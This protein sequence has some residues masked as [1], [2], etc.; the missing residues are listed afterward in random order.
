M[1]PYGAS[2][3]G[4]AAYGRA[5]PVSARGRKAQ[6]TVARQGL[7]NPNTIAQPT[8]YSVDSVTFGYGPYVG[9]GLD[10]TMMANMAR[11]PPGLARLDGATAAMVPFRLVTRPI[12]DPRQGVVT[13]GRKLQ[14]VAATQAR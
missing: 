9:I 11:A 14:Q 13:H 2:T 6:P 5:R 7:Y 12:V 1:P 10:S 3:Q 4:A 8:P